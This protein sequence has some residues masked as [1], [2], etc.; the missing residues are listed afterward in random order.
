MELLDGVFIASTNLIEGLDQATLR[1]FDV[2][3]RLGY[4]LV[5]QAFTLLSRHCAA[6]GVELPT[7]DD[8]AALSRLEV[9]TPG[10]FA[11]VARR[12]RFQRLTTPRE[13]IMALEGECA[14]K[15]AGRPRI[16]FR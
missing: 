15:E 4:L 10:D 8:R 7:K 12:Q 6:A 5:E 13:W 1:R 11:V 3:A 16:G 9:L 14:L 2:K